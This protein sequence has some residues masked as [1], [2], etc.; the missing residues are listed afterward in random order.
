LSAMN[1]GA[2]DCVAMPIHER[3]LQRVIHRAVEE[4]RHEPLLLST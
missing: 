2:F 1:L 3:E 4:P